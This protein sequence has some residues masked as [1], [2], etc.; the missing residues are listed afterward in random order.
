MRDGKDAAR[1]LGRR[2]GIETHGSR[3]F[4][5][6][7]DMDQLYHTLIRL[8]YLTPL[9]ERTL[10]LGLMLY[11]LIGR[12]GLAWVKR[13]YRRATVDPVPWPKQ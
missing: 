2:W 1:R 10:P 4:F 6:A 3:L 7:A 8:C 13:G 12:A 11:R 9:V 5:T